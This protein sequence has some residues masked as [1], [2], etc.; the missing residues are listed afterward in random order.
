MLNNINFLIFTLFY[1]GK[2]PASGT[3][4]SIFT[5]IFYFAFYNFFS[6]L[7]FVIIIIGVLLYSLFFL[8]KTLSNFS[9]NDPKEIIIDEFIGQLIPL[10]ICD[11][12]LLL[13]LL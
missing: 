2:L 12:N 6:N 11:G 13:I 10:I 1:V 4:G 5:I 7:I 3:F 9:K 8:R